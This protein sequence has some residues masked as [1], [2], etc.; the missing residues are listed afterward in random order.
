MQLE[1]TYIRKCV[2]LNVS[3]FLVFDDV[4]CRFG[5]VSATIRGMEVMLILEAGRVTHPDAPQQKVSGVV[6]T[7]TNRYSFVN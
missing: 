7:V 1:V 2:V 6:S 3:S 4:P 5:I